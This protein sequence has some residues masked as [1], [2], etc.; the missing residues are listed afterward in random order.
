MQKIK[1]RVKNGEIVGIAPPGIPEG[2]ELEVCL[3][4]PGD[5]MTELDVADLNR[6]LDI[7]WRSVQEER[8][9]PE[10]DVP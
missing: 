7:A 6:A 9:R 10:S 8:Q 2:T 5:D 1:V 3:F 4:D